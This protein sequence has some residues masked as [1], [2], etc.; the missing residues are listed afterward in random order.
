MYNPVSTIRIQFNKDFRLVDFERAIPFFVQLGI[1]TVYASPIFAAVPGSTHGYDVTNPLVINP[2][3]GTVA[4]LE[5]ISAT[6]RSH[7]IGW[8]QDIVPNHMAYHPLNPW[9]LDLLEKGPLSVY[10]E[11]FDVSWSGDYFNS[12]LMA[13][14]LETT[15]PDVIAT[16]DLQVLHTNDIFNFD[17]KGTAFPLSSRSYELIL[18]AGNRTMPENVQT[19]LKELQQLHQVEDRVQ[20]NLRWNELLIELKSLFKST[21]SDEYIRSAIAIVNSDPAIIEKLANLQFYRLCEWVETSHRINYRRFFT[22]NGLIGLNMQNEKVFTLYHGL[23]ADLC[24]QGIFDGVRVDH[25]D[26]LS[27]PRTYLRRL[28]DLLGPG[29][30]IA[31]EKILETGE[32]L[33]PAFPVQGTTGY[34]F[35]GVLNNVFSWRAAEDEL[36]SF[37]SSITRRHL[38]FD[39]RVREKKQ[40]I[41]DTALQGEL[42]NLA[43]SFQSL[44]SDG[45]STG[46]IRKAIAAVL[47][48]CPYYRLYGNKFPLDEYDTRQVGQILEACRRHHPDINEGIEAI[49]KTLLEDPKQ[50][51]G[52]F[53]ERVLRFYQRLMQLSGPLMAKGVEDTLMYTY[54]RFI[55]HNE[56][57]DSPGEFGI[58][59]GRFHSIMRERQLA[60]NLSLSATA[61]HDT[62]R[63]EDS[64][65]RL[66]VIT[67][68]SSEWVSCM[69][70]LMSANVSIDKN[71]QYLLFQAI[72]GSVESETD[73]SYPGRLEEFIRKA[74]REGKRHSSWEDPQ[75]T[76]EERVIAFGRDLIRKGSGFHSTINPVLEK[77]IQHGYVNSIVQLA[78]KAT[79]PGVPDFYQNS[80]T[81]DFSFVDPD[82]RRPVDFSGLAKGLQVAEKKTL[83]ELWD[84]RSDGL[85][86]LKLANDLIHLRR[87]YRDLFHTGKYLPLK[88]IGKYSEHV[89][90]FARAHQ[91][92]CIVIICMLHSARIWK[93]LDDGLKSIEWDDTRV[94]LPERISHEYTE[95]LSGTTDKAT[96]FVSPADIFK[97]LPVAVLDFTQSATN[98]S[99]GVLVHVT[100]LPS[101]DAVADLGPVS[102]AFADFLFE[103]KQRKWQWL[104]VTPTYAE[105]GFSPYSSLSS[106][107]G[108]RLLISHEDLADHG[109][110]HPDDLRVKRS[111]A[112]SA[113][114]FGSAFQKKDRLLAKP[115]RPPVPVR[116][117][118]RNQSTL[119]QRLCTVRIDL[120]TESGAMVPLAKSTAPTRCPSHRNV[121]SRACR[122]A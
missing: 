74:L 81:W 108:N 103:S 67:D 98:R 39:D 3:I 96:G 97:N 27:D 90:A 8:I 114:D 78:L 38:P 95:R 69:T 47:V 85:L 16:G 72:V 44:V 30:F 55:G 6:L 109:L 54:N 62:K 34:D 100:S 56:V 70:Q 119:A 118:Q 9:L 17:Y 33:D 18:A 22:V 43:D 122:R 21:V 115:C 51:K 29:K 26:G 52:D 88:V 110:L 31:V 45:P 77:I 42:N 10:H 23:I 94:M 79:C 82:N 41:L 116:A 20:Y 112:R 75:N 37:Y 7:S 11:F 58:S 19:F 66:S 92:S 111:A 87:E 120:E 121:G 93:D 35:L 2:E 89:I 57:G 15:L 76:L 99:A 12:R 117:V 101:T 84:N 5:R 14:F 65:M 105:A 46:E 4:E 60:S 49:A 40:L 68:I 64:R 61:T 13:P 107:A 73:A 71:V 104:P 32:Q 28:R 102:R 50:N 24:E 83:T 36:E 59:I 48:N 63:G 25:V 53:N 106:M 91:R 1:G 113:V 86:K 80:L